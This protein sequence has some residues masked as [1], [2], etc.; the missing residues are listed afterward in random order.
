MGRFGR[1]ADRP[2]VGYRRQLDSALVKE[3]IDVDIDERVPDENRDERAE[4]E[5]RAERNG[6]LA[7]RLRALAGDHD[8]AQRALR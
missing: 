5:E 4:R 3:V 6:G 7:S 2:H 1:R 8:D